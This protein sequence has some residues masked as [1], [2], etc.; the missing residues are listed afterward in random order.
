M[1]LLLHPEMGFLL[2][3][4]V[5][6]GVSL[7]VSR[8]RWALQ[9]FRS[10]TPASGGSGGGCFQ[11]SAT[12]PASSSIVKIKSFRVYQALLPLKRLLR[13]MGSSLLLLDYKTPP[14]LFS[15]MLSTVSFVGLKLHLLFVCCCC[16]CSCRNLSQKCK[17]DVL[18]IQT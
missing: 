2:V 13:L 10:F 8:W 11:W 15:S 6:S 4:E 3:L 7:G 5:K 9:W 14:F 12:F 1:N 17:R 18:V 16:T